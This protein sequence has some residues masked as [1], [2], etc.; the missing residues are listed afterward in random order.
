M[1][2]N[3][4]LFA[5]GSNGF[6]I[7]NV[8]GY[9][10]WKE[11]LNSDFR[12]LLHEDKTDY[13]FY[14][15]VGIRWGKEDLD[16]L[17]TYINHFHPDSEEDFDGYMPAKLWSGLSLFTVEPIELFQTDEEFPGLTKVFGNSRDE[18]MFRLYAKDGN[19]IVQELGFIVVKTKEFKKEDLIDEDDL[20]YIEK[21]NLEICDKCAKK[22]EHT[23]NFKNRGYYDEVHKKYPE[24]KNICEKCY[25]TL[26]EPFVKIRILESKKL[27]IEKEIANLK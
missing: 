14:V 3:C 9:K 26:K 2:R 10:R 22:I 11:T 8:E 5:G 23:F 15:Y 27:E 1:S 24:Y 18:G 7:K 21:E 19:V 25:K 4:E 13:G 17:D 6:K 12:F 16:E 20:E